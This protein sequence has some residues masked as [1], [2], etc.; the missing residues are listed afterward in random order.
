VKIAFAPERVVLIYPRPL[1]AIGCSLRLDN[2]YPVRYN[3]YVISIQE[4]E[5]FKDWIGNLKDRTG[6]AIINARIRRVSVGNFGDCKSIGDG[7]S[8]LIIDYGP[9][10]RVYFIEKGKTIILLLNGGKKSSQVRDIEAAKKIA[11]RIEEA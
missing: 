1:G 11:K 9:G 5:N 4:T 7:I 10:Y 2:L 8:E 3:S 6:Q